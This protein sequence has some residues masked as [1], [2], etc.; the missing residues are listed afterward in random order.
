MPIAILD[1]VKVV[2]FAQNVAVPYCG[3][4]LAGM[5]ADVIK[6]EPPGGDAMRHLAPVGPDEGKA[7]AV[8]N[9]G[10]RSMVLDL[11]GPDAP[12]VVGNLLSW[13][14]VALIGLKLPDLARFG[15]DW[16]SAR[17]TNRQ[18]VYLVA[19]AFGPE[20]PDAELGGYDVLAQARSGAGFVL[21]RTRDG[22][23]IASRPAVVDVGTG[24]ASA[25]GV[26]AALRHRDQTGEGQR[27]DTSLLGT[28]MA[29]ATPVVNYFESVDSEAIADLRED[30]AILRS[31][32][33]DFESQRE[34]YENRVFAGGG[35]F[36][37]YF[38]P[39]ATVDGMVS[40]AGLSPTLFKKFHAITG[41]SKPEEISSTS[42]EMA[43][44]ISDVEA[45]FRTKTTA[46][47]L[48]IF[49]EAGYPA[50][51]Y[52]D[53][54]EALED[55]QVLANDYVV[56]SE[57]PVFGRYLASGLPIRFEQGP[58]LPP[59]RSPMLGEHTAEILE[60]VRRVDSDPT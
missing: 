31:S 55:T 59:T 9:G 54:Y 58:L 22:M 4:L 6:V 46:E 35:A 21:N 53:P 1:G 41:I 24:L 14:D 52:N 2:E 7:Y 36:R 56:E 38:R 11:D 10:K 26:V 45:L 17:T 13:A 44:T 48:T 8:V 23:P 40:V 34:V 33:A 27:V 20:G 16:E 15:L 19:T 43:D 57:H 18:L 29:L 37:L 32:G 49:R 60:E 25:L 51:P 50:A 30:L 28:A 47:W 3:R 39:Y 12:E 5:G 42:V